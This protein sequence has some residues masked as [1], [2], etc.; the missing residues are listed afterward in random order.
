MSTNE[1]TSIAHIWNFARDFPELP[2]SLV[3]RPHLLETMSDVLHGDSQVV[4]LEGEEGDGATTTLGQFCKIY[5]ETT[6]SLFIKPASRFAY[7][8]DYLRLTLA[9]Q[10]Y[11]YVYGRS[12]D[13]QHL[14]ESEFNALFLRVVG[15]QRSA[16]L[17]FVVDGLHQIPMEDG[18]Y[19]ADILRNV[20]PIGMKN[21]RFLI[22]GQQSALGAH[23]KNIKSK[24]YQQLKFKLEEAK[25]FFQT[26][27][28]SDQE[29]SD[30]HL[31]CKGVPGRM[32]AV[33]R[34]LDGG[35][36]LQSVLESDPSKYLQF[37]RLEFS[38]LDD[39]NND[40]LTVIATVAF[41][42]KTLQLSELVGISE[43]SEEVTNQA[44]KLCRF[45]TINAST[46]VVEFISESHRRFAEKELEAFKRQ[47]LNAQ[48]EYL[49]KN[50]KSDVALRFLP[51]Y[52]ESLN[53]LDAIL[54]LIS[55]EHYGDL[56]DSSQSLVALRNRAELGARSAET[57]K[58]THDV[59]RFALQKSI[60]VTLATFE[61]GESEMEAL[62]SLGMPEA[63][64]ALADRAVAK[65]DRL[66]L[67]AKYAR[68]LKEKKGDIGTD[69]VDYIEKLAKEI[70]FA[71]L[72]DKAMTI[73]ADVLIFAPDFAVYII[74][75][76]NKGSSAAQ[77]DAAYTHLSITAS[78]AN[79]GKK[80][81]IDDKA[82]P[83]ISDEALQEVARSFGI[84]SATFDKKELF[85]TVERMT[86]GRQ[87]FFLRSFVKL[88]RND[89]S[90][91][92]IIEYS[93]DA[94]VRETSYIPKS[95]DLSDLAVPLTEKNV[96][97]D[98]LRNL[99]TR[100]D[101]QMGLLARSAFSKDLTQLQLRLAA[102]E[103]QYDTDLAR[104]RLHQAYYDISEILTP[105]VQLECYVL[106]LSAL[107]TLDDSGELER[108]DG[109]RALIKD[110]LSKL[111]DV[112]LNNTGENYLA[113][114]GALRALA[115]DDPAAAIALAHRL[116]TEDRRDKAFGL[117]S[118]SLAAA[119]F[120]L[121]RHKAIRASIAQITDAESRSEAVLNLLDV[122]EANKEKRV[123]QPHVQEFFEF[124]IFPVQVC[125][126]HIWN[127]ST[128]SA[129]GANP[130]VAD[131][132]STLRLEVSKIESELDQIDF[133]F[134]AA[135]AMSSID[136]PA[137]KV[138]YE[139]GATKKASISPNT[140]SS[141]HLFDLCLD[142]VSRA[143]APLARANRLSEDL[144]DR[145]IALA[146]ASPSVLSRIRIFSDLAERAWCA[147]RSDLSTRIVLEQVRPLLDKARLLSEATFC[148]A[149]GRALPALCIWHSLSAF[150]Y[151][152]SLSRAK[153]DA[154]LYQ[155]A[156]LR[157]RKIPTD[158]PYFEDQF[159]HSRIEREDA[160]EVIEILKRVDVDSVLCSLL[161]SFVDAVT[162]KVNRAKFSS[163]QRADFA[164]KCQSIVNAKLPD[165]RNIQHKGFLV[166]CLALTYKMEDKQYSAWE[167]LAAMTETI[168][169]VADKGYVCQKLA[170]AMPSKFD[171]HRRV[172]MEKAIQLFNRI[173]SPIDRLTHL[174]GYAEMALRNNS[175]DSAKL[176]LRQA[177]QLSMEIE[178]NARVAQ[179]R[180]Q[181]IDL[182]YQAS[183]ELAEELIELID[184]DPARFQLKADSKKRVALAIAKKNVANAKMIKDATEC[185]IEMLPAAAWKNMAAL[186]AGRLEV[187]PLDLMSEYVSRVRNCS[188]TQAH[189]VLSWHLEN[190]AKKYVSA[191]DAEKQIAPISEALLLSTEIAQSIIA[192]VTRQ[193]VI[194]AEDSTGGLVV[195]SQTR[196]GA[197]EFIE[198][199]I[200][201]NAV[202]RI[203]ICDP[204]FSPKDL[205][206]L[207]IILAQS[208]HCKVFVLASKSEL[209]KSGVL[210]VEAFLTPWRNE[211]VQDPPETEVIAFSTA[212]T[213]KTVIHDRWLLTNGV[214]LR[215]GTS[216][217]S[218]GVGKL[219]EISEIEP[220]R[221][222][223]CEHQLNQYISRQRVIDGAKIQYLSFTL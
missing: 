11:W 83:K 207:R 14:D 125:E 139:L 97:L 183:P 35:T 59:F 113:V 206:L 107:R 94:I 112:V 61:G 179:H 122:L 213:D 205:Q 144:L 48:V 21:C 151:V 80:A 175:R 99:V 212:D 70:D 69:L 123:W 214:G 20:L 2:A 145:Y 106:M 222:A 29:I 77:K 200:H 52:Y 132:T 211:C 117:I 194:Q 100:F 93:L 128:S 124:L 157:L 53:D 166:V 56:L 199:W 79:M 168:T 31:L 110:D 182:A 195:R 127:F 173:P 221:A 171:T 204:F 92:E 47:S 84:L 116:N 159:D 149:V 5:E 43:K 44:L 136:P 177:M 3:D 109:F 216:F 72:G 178:N 176:V 57:L 111:L 197:I 153:R 10:Y 208:P 39:M 22:T 30:V 76:A 196:E 73:A 147:K 133:C 190:L 146:S 114:I 24:P 188:L 63:A 102:A 162:D 155:A 161:E 148:S 215:F 6:F 198:K 101:S 62:V 51:T 85:Q 58:R 54:N 130:S 87:I 180:R 68:K 201:A 91:L 189:P 104:S 64:L 18:R 209:R 75:E 181:V 203:T 142:L 38:V 121:D 150:D 140:G 172:L 33:R 119:A 65:D 4:F 16:N 169:N 220:A 219:S 105:E 88:R 7:S 160:I 96:D 185:E 50:P 167:A 45:V 27:K 78:L 67:L 15:K 164:V 9:E 186:A 108:K 141:L 36:T 26:S 71:E 210:S 82:R 156:M 217:N 90:V 1:S 60:F 143:L 95:R 191:G 134:K 163:Q 137:A 42:K 17:Y 34:L 74:D 120:S 187:K 28:L 126:W 86:A 81:R 170:D 40:Q 118:R 89:P 129:A 55:K 192:K 98:R 12:I 46:N 135:T 154:A 174:E 131:F 152:A 19:V 202:D 218:V 32:A 184:D 115:I 49:R 223:S 165:L 8:P 193:I 66:A 158:E 103:S 23:L 138:F 13:K 41:S 37:I 25:T